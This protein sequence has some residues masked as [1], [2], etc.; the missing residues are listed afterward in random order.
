LTLPTSLSHA[1]TSI[2]LLIHSRRQRLTT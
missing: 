1:K 2:H